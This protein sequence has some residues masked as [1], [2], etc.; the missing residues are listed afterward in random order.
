MRRELVGEAA[1][2]R[3]A[4]V[5]VQDANFEQRFQQLQSQKQQILSQNADKTQAQT[6]INQLEKQLFNDAERKRL[7]GYAALQSSSDNKAP[8]AFNVWVSP[9]SF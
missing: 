2:G 9:N 5:D 4:Q 6:Q 7:A 1:A 8:W 3:L